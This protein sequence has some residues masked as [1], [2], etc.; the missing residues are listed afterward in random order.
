MKEILTSGP[1]MSLDRAREILAAEGIQMGRTTIWR[2]ATKKLGLSFQ[3]ASLKPAVVFGRQTMQRRFDYAQRVNGLPDEE[4]WFLDESGFNLHIAPLRCWAP[5]GRTPSIA[6]PTNRGVNVSLLMCISPTGVVFFKTKVG[7]FKAP[8]FVE[9]LDAL[10][11]HCPEVRNGEVCLVMD[12][13]RIH[14]S[15]ASQAFLRENDIEHIYLPPYSPDLNPIENV[16]GVLKSRC[17]SLGVVQNRVELKRRIE[18]VILSM[19][20]NLNVGEFYRRMRQFVERA[21]NR[22]SFN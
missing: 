22:E 10:A 13:A 6:V 18:N 14:H 7:S 17:R 11:D 2:I 16:F 12:N 15:R 19:N 21:L 9:F 4:L 5:K 20:Q 8:D 1:T 3:K